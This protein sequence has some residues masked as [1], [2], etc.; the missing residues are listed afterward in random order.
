MNPS[1]LESLVNERQA[2]FQREA[3]Q[4]DRVP[5]KAP[6]HARRRTSRRSYHVG[7]VLIRIGERLAGPES[8]SRVTPLGS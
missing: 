2:E 8:G 4:R 3:R 5:V 1:Q 7:I 6:A